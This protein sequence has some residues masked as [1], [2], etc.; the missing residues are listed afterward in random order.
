MQL[1]GKRADPVLMAV[2][3]VISMMGI[4]WRVCWVRP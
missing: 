2:G 3:A 4:D 1:D